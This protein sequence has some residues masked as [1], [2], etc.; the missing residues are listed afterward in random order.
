M[1]ARARRLSECADHDGVAVGVAEGEFARA[2]GGVDVGFFFKGG[3]E[4][5]CA[6][7]RGV[8]IVDAEE[9]DETVAGRGVIGA[10]ECG[11]IVFAP[12]MEADEDFAVRVGDLAEIIVVRRDVRLA[13]E[14]L[15]PGAALE[16]VG[17][18]DNGPDALHGLS[19]AAGLRVCAR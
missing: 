3:D 8:E 14:R 13:E 11:V 16:H 17:D 2:G 1:S 6:G 5:A 12:G 7:E 15:I 18:A 10:G 4:R 9:E 19:P